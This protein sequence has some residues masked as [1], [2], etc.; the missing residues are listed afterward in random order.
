MSELSAQRMKALAYL[1]QKLNIA[2]QKAKQT[3]EQVFQ[4]CEGL[5]DTQ[6][7]R[8]CIRT[9]ALSTRRSLA[10]SPPPVS[11]QKVV[12]TKSLP[13]CKQC[14]SN[15]KVTFKFDQRRS[16]D[17]GMTAVYTCDKCKIFWT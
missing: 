1:E 5:S 8:S 13:Y 10:Q 3:E 9:T 6:K 11:Q 17:E 12:S 7:Y 4:Q 16:G 15:E 2:A 14:K